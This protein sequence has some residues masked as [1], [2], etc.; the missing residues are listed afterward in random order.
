[1]ATI[2]QPAA[3]ATRSYG[4]FCGL[5]RALDVVGDRWTLLIVRELLIRE[6]R[7]TELLDSLPHVATNLLADRL[8][9][10]ESAG[11]V[12]RTSDGQGRG[13]RY[14]LT[15]W[16]EQL[17]EPVEALVRWSAPLMVAG[18]EGD[19]FRP[20]W[21]VAALGALLRHRRADPGGTVGLEVDGTVIAVALGP[22]GPTV[23]LAGAT[24]PATVLSAPADTVLGLAAGVLTPAQ[25]VEAGELSGERADLEA[26]FGTERSPS[27]PHA[28]R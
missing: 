6:A 12:A 13:G 8:R 5:A 26:V 19:E 14:R 11:V 20:H 9:A 15:P 22:D 10:L 24:P 16:G 21:L 27:R 17:R 4:Q 2:A 1:M 18:R 28:G 3:A 23:A 25:A 7:Y